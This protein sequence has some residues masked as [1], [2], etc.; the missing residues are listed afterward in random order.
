M[1][2]EAELGLSKPMEYINCIIFCVVYKNSSGVHVHIMQVCYIS[3]HVPC[4]FAAPISSSFT[5]SISFISV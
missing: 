5:V 4:W 2:L 1:C 3:I